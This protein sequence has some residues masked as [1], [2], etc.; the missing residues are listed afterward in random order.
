MNF[1]FQIQI[2]TKQNG[3]RESDGEAGHTSGCCKI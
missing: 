3:E 1:H 2:K